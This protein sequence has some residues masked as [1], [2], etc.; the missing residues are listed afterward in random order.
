MKSVA[1]PASQRK[2]FTIVELLTVMSII[3]ILIGLLIPALNKVKQYATNVKQSA[4][5]HSIEAAVELFSNEFEG[6]PE[7]DA[8][9]PTG[10]SYCGAMKLCE[11][12]MGQDLLGVH[13]NTVFRADGFGASGDA[14][15]PL[16]PQDI[17]SMDATARD[18]NLKARKG[19]YLQ[20]ENANAYRMEDIYSDTAPFLPTS[21]VLC[22]VYGRRTANGQKTGMPILYYKAN[23]AYSFHDPSVAVSTTDNSGN[24]Y[25]YWDN[26][27]LVV[28]GKP[29]DTSSGSTPHKLS[30]TSAEGV[31]R[32]FKNTQSDKIVT[33]SRPY[34]ADTFI[35]ISAGYDG[36]YGTAD[37]ICNYEWNYEE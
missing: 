28:L 11:A 6:Y 23:T 19:P 31:T 34:N 10:A 29:W 9:D 37:D 4:Q 21:F 20:P 17:D 16:Y 13:S 15:N 8:L 14:A 26:E 1:N 12:I 7:S 25:N 32:F 3:V 30:V 27:E 18:N 2:A 36:E 35:L 5:F 24:I 33:A 22:D